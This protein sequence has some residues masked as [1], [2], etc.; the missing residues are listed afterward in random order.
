[1]FSFESNDFIIHQKMLDLQKRILTLWF[2]FSPVHVNVLNLL[3]G[4]NFM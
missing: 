1:M 2:F 3:D 4:K